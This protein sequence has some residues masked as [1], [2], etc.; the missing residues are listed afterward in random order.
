MQNVYYSRLGTKLDRKP[1]LCLCTLK[2]V[3]SWLQKSLVTQED[4]PIRFGK[5]AKQGF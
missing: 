3:K 4:L 5:E 1:D 2:P